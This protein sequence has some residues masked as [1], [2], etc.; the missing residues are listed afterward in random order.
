MKKD[1]LLSLVSKRAGVTKK[2]ADAVI[3]AYLEVAAE[4]M[5]AGNKF[6]LAGIGT[7][8]IKERA[9]RTVRNPRT[10]EAKTAPACNVVKFTAAKSIKEKING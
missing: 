2:D 8:S 4:D 6:A 1:E 9:E 3:S 5:A 10:G 7:L